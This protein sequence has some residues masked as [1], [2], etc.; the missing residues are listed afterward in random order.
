MAF[1]NADGVQDLIAK[2][3]NSVSVAAEY[4]EFLLFKYL[5]IKAAAHGKMAIVGVD[6]TNMDNAAIA[7]RGA[8][9][10]LEFMSTKF[11]ESGV[12]TVTKKADQCIFMDADFN[13]KYDVSVLAAAFNMDK[14]EFMGKLYLIDDWTS[15]DN[16]RFSDIMSGSDMIS[17]VTNEELAIMRDIHAV[18]V[19]KEW[20]QIY[21]NQNKFT[22]KYVASGEYWNYFYNVWKTVSTS[23]FS[24]AIAFVNEPA[25]APATIQF[26]VTDKT[27]GEDG[28]VL[29]LEL[30][31]EDAVKYNQQV[32]FMGK[33]DSAANMVAIHKYGAIVYPPNAKAVNIYANMGG[34]VYRSTT[35]GSTGGEL[36]YTTVKA[37]DKVTFIKA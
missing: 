21:D 30:A 8:S 27:V 11:N 34:T 16:Q 32:R 33:G 22:E 25:A 6:Y 31:N 12:H 2:I 29:V 9:N 10:K 18:V 26:D 24:N 36:P 19:D 4:D 35:N 7:F 23:P 3:V 15:F 5:I 28:T 13:A 14:A 37:G 1:L 20:F 17:P